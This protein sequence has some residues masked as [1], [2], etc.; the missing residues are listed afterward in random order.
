MPIKL[1]QGLPAQSLLD[2]EGIS[3]TDRTAQDRA[4]EK[5]IS[6]ALLNLMPHKSDTEVQIARLLGDTPYRVELSLFVPDD[7]TSKN[8]PP[9]HI[10]AHYRRWSEIRYST[11]D[12]LIVTGA[13]VETL[14]FEDVT[15][16][17]EL[18]QVF[19]WAR[20]HVRRSY[21]I[22]WAAQAALHHF[23][24]VPKHALAEKRFGVFGHRVT[25]RSSP[26]LDGFGRYFPVPVSRHSE[27]RSA[28]LP[29]HTDLSVLAESDE[30]GLCLLES[31]RDRAVYMFNHLE[32][33]AETLQGEYQRDLA[34]GRSVPMPKNYFPDGDPA[35]DPVNYWRSHAR[36][37]FRNWLADI[38]GSIARSKRH[39]LARHSG[40]ITTPATTF[41]GCLA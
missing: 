38:D 2:A 41:A 24:G 11:F 3:A 32:Y 28:D 36:L 35:A 9:E 12:G 25:D 30:A 6:V 26:L 39:A 7:Y 21:Y 10:A 40:R 8:T 37:L 17:R 1:P 23:H 31:E 4:G 34:V 27:V 16:W 14:P 22:C 5:T 29:T 18:T 13:P 15:Y 20:T 19:D 33:D